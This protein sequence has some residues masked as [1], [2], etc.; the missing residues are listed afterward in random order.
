MARQIF[1]QEALD[2]L[3]SP[4]QLDQLM[5][6]A[7]PRAW[8]ALAAVGLLL[9]MALLWGLRGTI[10]TTVEAQGILLRRGVQPLQAPYAGVATHVSVISGDGAAKGQELL[11]LTPSEPGKQE[12]KPVTCPFNA[13]VLAR[14]VPE[15]ASVEKGATLFVLEPL[16]EPLRA[17]LFVP[18]SEGYQVQIG[19]KVQV[20]PTPVKKSDYGYLVGE[21][22]GAVKFPITQEEMLRVVQNDELARQF[23]SAGPCLQVAVELT[24]DAETVSGYRWSS[25]RGAPLQ[26]YSGMPCEARI[27]V[28]EQRPI[29]LVFP[30]L[31]GK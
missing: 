5:R 8:A 9:L 20:W 18:V 10:P 31:G 13:R 23:S 27:I 11:W 22:R 28:S 1:R 25:S 12:A 4:E 24:P 30:G 6:V 21:I 19:M 15:G 3:S 26:L 17:R 29:Q 16:D 7:S 2:R 14:R